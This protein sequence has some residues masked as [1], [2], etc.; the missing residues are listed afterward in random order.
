MN[1]QEKL[2]TAIRLSQS[3]ILL[4]LKRNSDSE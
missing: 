4:F 2:N 3:Y 1:N